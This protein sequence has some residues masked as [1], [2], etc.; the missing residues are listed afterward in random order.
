[1]VST[2]LTN[3]EIMND[4]LNVS[5]IEK[6]FE[7]VIALQDVSI[8]IQRGELVGIFG[9]N[10]AGKTTLFNVLSGIV[11]PERGAIAFKGQ[12]TMDMQPHRIAMSGIARS[13][14]EV[15]IIRQLTVLDNVL[16]YFR[17]QAGERLLNV[18]FRPRLWAS[19][20]TENR[21]LVLSLLD[22]ASLA[23]KASRF[24]DALSYGEQ[25]LLNLICCL[26]GGSELLLLDEPVAGIA[27][28]MMQRILSIILDIPRDGK[29]VIIIEHN[30]DALKQVCQ[31]LVFMDAGRKIC[32][33]T[34]DNVLNDPRVI[35]AYLD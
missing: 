34:P 9:P 12:S 11:R 28:E 6:R 17:K 33:G 19:Q 3:G 10:G 15:R 2:V 5:G 4:L 14:Q 30:L 27:P 8:T 26:A 20:E 32:E 31:K 22:K 7:G 35:E 21:K 1:M 24:A 18:F 13:F 29:A 23:D 16:M 25:K